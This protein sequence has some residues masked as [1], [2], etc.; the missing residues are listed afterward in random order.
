MIGKNGISRCN[1]TESSSHHTGEKGKNNK[2]SSAQE[3]LKVLMLLIMQYADC[4]RLK[5][6]EIHTGTTVL[7][8]TEASITKYLS[9]IQG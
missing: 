6:S 9:F 1:K 7:L 5:K 3:P 2:I 4:I 8:L